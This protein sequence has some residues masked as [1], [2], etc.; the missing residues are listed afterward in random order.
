MP[1]YIGDY[2]ADTMRLSNTQHGI[3]LLLIMAYWRDG[4]PLPDDDEELAAITKCSQQEWR[5]QRPLIARFFHIEDGK[6]SHTRI[7][8]ELNEATSKTQ[9]RSKAGTEGARKRWQRDSK[10]IAEP[11]ANDMANDMA[12]PMANASQTAWQNDAPLPS[13][14]PKKKL[15]S[16]LPSDSLPRGWAEQ[17]AEVR[18]A[19]GLPSAD[20]AAEWLKFRGKIGEEPTIERWLGWARKAHTARPGNGSTDPSAMPEPP[21]PQRCRAWSRGLGW[22]PDWGPEPSDPGCWAP[23]ELVADAVRRRDAAVPAK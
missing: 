19:E 2:L 3:Y 20:L 17:A 13:P 21:W 16:N 4:A 11:M 18:A 9:E 12:T 1:L 15:A 23:A 7:D 22:H 6:W 14:S 8:Y 5:K 10:T